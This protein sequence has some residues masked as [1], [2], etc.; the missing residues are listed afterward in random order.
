MSLAN[1][2][3]F[4]RTCRTDAALRESLQQW[5]PLAEAEPISQIG[6]HFT[7]RELAE[8]FRLEWTARWA[9]YDRVQE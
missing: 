5:N 6:Y 3:Q 9:H 2:L 1:A 7:Q 4:L 8:A